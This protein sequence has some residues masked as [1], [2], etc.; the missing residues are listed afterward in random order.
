MAPLRSAAELRNSG[1]TADL[2]F[3]RRWTVAS[4]AAHNTLV[5]AQYAQ[6]ARNAAI[7]STKV[8]EQRSN[9]YYSLAILA[10][11]TNDLNTSKSSLRAAISCAPK[12]FKPHWSLARL[13]FA[14]GHY[15]EARA[16]AQLAIN[17]NGGKDSEVISTLNEIVRSAESAK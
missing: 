5:R 17:L 4:S 16:E 1:V 7:S 13:L 15:Q 8:P 3:S 10:A 9:A 6:F 2:Y 11:G 14:E 12:W